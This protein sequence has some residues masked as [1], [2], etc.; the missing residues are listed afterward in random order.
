MMVFLRSFRLGLISMFPNVVPLFAGGALLR[1][2]GQ[3]LD[4]GTVLVASVCLG[5]S[6][7]DTSHVLANFAYHRRQGVPPNQ[8]MRL[9]M[10]RTGPALLS[11][12]GILIA[13]F[14]SF[15]T[16]TFVPNIY[17]GILT[18]FILSDGAAR[19]H[20]LHPCPAAR[21]P[22]SR[23]RRT[24]RACRGLTGAFLSVLFG[25]G[26]CAHRT[27][28]A[29]WRRFTQDGEVKFSLAPLA[30]LGLLASAGC[31]ERLADNK[32]TSRLPPP[33]SAASNL[34]ARPGQPRVPRSLLEVPL[35]SLTGD[36]VKLAELSN[37]VT[38]IAIW[39]TWCKPCLME[40]PF[41][42]AVKRRYANDPKVSVVAVSIDEVDTPEELGQVQATVKRLGVK[43]PVF[44]D[45]TGKLSRHLMG[46]IQS[47]PLLAILDRDLRLLRERGFD[48]SID[49][50]E[51]VEEKSALIEL[52]RKGELPAPPPPA[53]EDAHNGAILAALRANLRRAYPELSEERIE[54]LLQNLEE[55]MEYQ[56]QM[57]RG[58]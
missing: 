24:D 5:I 48:T 49:Q 46:A 17:F 2:L 30:C 37:Q 25:V 38:V 45:Q 13:S 4:M 16:A 3:P 19:R 57:R 40:L 56:K 36:S 21:S 10:A 35:T 14:A 33:S 51:Y 6:I 1:L 58:R 23:L 42:D 7:D 18:A 55:R 43:L 44:V 54:E 31:A 47:V 52:A 9:V 15:A 34:A 11:T 32:P 41:L 50:K 20:V 8:A 53:A 26:G 22:P 29:R 12:N 28:L 27:P 39:A